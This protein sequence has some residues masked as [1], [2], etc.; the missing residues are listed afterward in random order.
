M[1]STYALLA[2]TANRPLAAGIADR[3]GSQLQPCHIERFPDGEV[4]VEIEASVRDKLRFRS[5]THLAASERPPN[6]TT[7]ACRCLRPRGE[8]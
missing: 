3:L 1:K 6:R 7:S 4:G 5:P 8:A 2:G